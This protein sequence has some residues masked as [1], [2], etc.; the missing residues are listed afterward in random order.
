MV[1][2][3]YPH[4]TSSCESRELAGFE[5]AACKCLVQ[6]FCV[7]YTSL[8]MTLASKVFGHHVARCWLFFIRTNF[9]IMPRVA[10]PMIRLPVVWFQG[11]GVL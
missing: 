8:N 4:L 11:F 1:F 6:L 3:F 2:T 5:L 10:K 7:S 9:L